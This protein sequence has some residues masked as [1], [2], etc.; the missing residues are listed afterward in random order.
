[1]P[2]TLGQYLTAN[3]LNSQE[4]AH[5]LG[6]GVVNGLKVIPT[7]PP[8]M[9]VHVEIGKAYVADTLVEKGA[10]TDL[11]VTAADPI[12]PRKDIVVC[13]SAGIL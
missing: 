10:V 3:D 6:Y 9:D 11:T 13:S 8:D 1:M 7:G 5:T 12:N 4:L 2:F